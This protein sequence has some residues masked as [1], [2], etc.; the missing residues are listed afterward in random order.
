MRDMIMMMIKKKEEEED[1]EIQG[2]S[3]EVEIA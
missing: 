3:P 1:S 2:Y